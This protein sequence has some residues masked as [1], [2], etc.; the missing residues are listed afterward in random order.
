MK[1]IAQLEDSVQRLI[2]AVAEQ[3]LVSEGYDDAE[4]DNALENVRRE[5]VSNVIDE[6]TE[7]TNN[8]TD[9]IDY[10]M[11]YSTMKGE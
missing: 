4:I 2:M 10:H 8:V 9:W 6:L 1:Y 11:R 5:K 3:K 7:Y